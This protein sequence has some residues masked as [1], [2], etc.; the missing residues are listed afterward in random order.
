MKNI[1]KEITMKAAHNVKTTP[2]EMPPLLRIVLYILSAAVCMFSGCTEITPVTPLDLAVPVPGVLG[3]APR[4][5]GRVFD[6]AVGDFYSGKALTVTDQATWEFNGR[7]SSAGVFSM[8]LR[9]PS[10]VL[11]MTELAFLLGGWAD[12]EGVPTVAFT[13]DS[14]NFT[15]ETAGCLIVSN[16][17]TSDNR[18]LIHS[19]IWDDESD[20]LLPIE[21]AYYVYTSTNVT[22]SA[23]FTATSVDLGLIYES[24]AESFSL[25]LKEGWNVFRV[26]TVLEDDEENNTFTSRYQIV[27][28]E[29]ANLPWM[30]SEPFD[31]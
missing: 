20:M 22:L 23:P 7:I 14:S 9:T 26:I 21:T 29:N 31:F 18:D 13:F 11:P 15:A 3:T 16:M 1:S 8:A 6:P 10:T 17:I 24:T 25:N 12:E 28:G 2:N 4:I 30:L 19:V 5:S 27:Q